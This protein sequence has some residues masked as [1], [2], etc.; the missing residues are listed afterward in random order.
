M[1]ISISGMPGAGKSTVAKMLSK[2]LEMK[3]Y[4]MGGMRREMGRK[5]GMTIEQLNEIGENEEWT[6][7]DV[8][9][10]QKELRNKEDNFIIDGRTSFF[11]IPHSLKIFLD[12]DFH[13]GA[14]RIYDD[15]RS[16]TTR[17]ECRYKTLSDAEKAVRKRMESDIRRCKKY[18]GIDIHDK[19]KFDIVINTT[20]MTPEDV[21][22]KIIR[23]VE[24]RSGK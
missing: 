21:A 8:D 15:V 3:R 24:K 16:N 4:Y 19:T 7:K 11:L 14:K 22:E 5:R 2:R 20:K 13:V 1:I 10:Y 17:N 12:V 23:E 9:D 18:H 6:D